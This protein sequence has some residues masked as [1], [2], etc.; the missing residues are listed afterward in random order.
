MAQ[1]RTFFPNPQARELQDKPKKPAGEV[2]K[3]SALP[4]LLCRQK[5]RALLLSQ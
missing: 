3:K 4:A 5:R 2:L 1:A